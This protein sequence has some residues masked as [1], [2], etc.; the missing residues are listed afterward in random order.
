MTPRVATSSADRLLAVLQLF[1]PERPEWTVETAAN[2]IGVS[3]ST[4]YRYFRSL[5]RLKLSGKIPA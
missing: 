3:V 5:C 4:A 1:T 2:E